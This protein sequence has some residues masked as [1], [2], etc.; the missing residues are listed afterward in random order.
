MFLDK[1]AV[2][3]AN[4]LYTWMRVIHECALYDCHGLL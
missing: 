1:L 4:A 2:Y 3:Y